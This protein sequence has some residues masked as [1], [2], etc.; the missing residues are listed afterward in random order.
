MFHFVLYIFSFIFLLTL[1]YSFI[2]FRL[3][4]TPSHHISSYNNIYLFRLE[5]RL[6]TYSFTRFIYLFL[7]YFFFCC[8]LF[9]CFFFF[10][11]S[12]FSIFAV[13][14]FTIIVISFIRLLFPFLWLVTFIFYIQPLYNCNAITYILCLT[15][16]YDI[17]N[18]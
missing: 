13:S 3:W 6:V 15:K 5:L 4:S 9:C 14:Q 16:W 18:L 1:I 12:L 11:F 8:V 7:F 10:F 17:Y 2:Q